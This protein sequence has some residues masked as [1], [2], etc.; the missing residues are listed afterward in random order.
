LPGSVDL[1]SALTIPPHFAGLVDDAAIFPPGNA[2]LVDAVADHLRRSGATYAPFI[3]PLVITD[4]RLPDLVDILADHDPVAPLPVSVVATGGAGS[5]AGAVRWSTGTGLVSLVGL[6]IALPH[7]GDLAAAVRRVAVAA[8]DAGLEA[9]LFIEPP[10][11]RG[12]PTAPW[13]AA[14]DAIADTGHRAKFRT[15]GVTTDLFP[16]SVDVAEWISAAL[17]RELPFKCTAGLHNAIRHRDPETGFEHQG[18]L[19]ILIATRAAWD[20]VAHDLIVSLLEET[21]GHSLATETQALGAA[22]IV[23]T[24]QWFTSFGSCDVMEPLDDLVGLGLIE[25]GA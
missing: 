10:H 7:E 19:N 21:D 3:G 15:G 9:P 25:A 16:P 24:R 22:G 23:A 4:L 11:T 5:L 14:L 12:A 8:D 2:S 20:G 13:F 18:F 1:V 17:D 6:E